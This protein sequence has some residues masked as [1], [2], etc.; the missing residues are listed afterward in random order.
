ML[1][2]HDEFLCHQLASTFDHV[3]DSG[4]QWTE[5][6]W[7]CAYDISGKIHLTSAF[8][9]YPN[10]NI[11][12]GLG[13]LTIDGKTQYNVRASRELRPQID[14]VKVGLLSYEVMEG[15]K[16]VRWALG[17]NDYGISYEVEFEGRM[18][19]HE[20][21]PQFAR[22]RG[23]LVENICRYAQCGRASGWV[24][25][26][27]KTYDIK[28]DTWYAHRDHSWGIRSTGVSMEQGLPPGEPFTGLFFN[29]NLIQFK[30]W[31]ISCH[32]REDH[33]GNVVYFSGGMGYAYGDSRPGLQLVSVEHNY[34]FDPSTRQLKSGRVIYTAAD[35]SKVD[36]SVRA[37]THL[38]L[39]PGGYFTYKGFSHGVWMGPDWIDGEKLNVSDSKV[40]QE[41]SLLND[42][43]CECR[44]GNDIGY[45][46]VEIVM[47][48]KHPQYGVQ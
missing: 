47:M 18:P 30:D 9:K 31:Y 24:K 8:G 17:E 26:Q 37:L 23:R 4:V 10:R 20:E 5:R 12:D 33:N 3:A 46:I 32:L 27:G 45:G 19:A 15:L 38:H 13:L 22:S 16:K 11:I 40:V 28:P 43:M 48:G 14:D 7:C 21:V 34:Q 25:V 1:T 42:N 39:W 6:L 41:V 29:W 2:K 36:I 35:G 44:C